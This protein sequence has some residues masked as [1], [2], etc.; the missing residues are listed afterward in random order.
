MAAAEAS[1]K[2]KDDKEKEASKKK[3]SRK[4]QQ[5]AL[6]TVKIAINPSV[7]WEADVGKDE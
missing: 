5:I 4:P 7:E 2:D 6:L 1:K 3:A